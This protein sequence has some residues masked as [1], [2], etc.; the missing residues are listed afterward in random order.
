MIDV[1]DGLIADLGHIARASRVAMELRRE[2]VEVPTVMAD[3]AAALGVDP[4]RWVFTGG[5]DHAL[6]ATFPATTELS[7]E[8]RMI[9]RVRDGEGVTVD[10]RRFEGPGGWDHF[11]G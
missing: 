5:D 6:A 9:G 1:S 2:A 8:W 3:A 10:G 7:R 4:Y 11:G